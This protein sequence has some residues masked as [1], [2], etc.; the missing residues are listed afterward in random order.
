MSEIAK[1]SPII[2]A[3]GGHYRLVPSGKRPLNYDL[4]ASAKEEWT[5]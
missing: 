5:R 1:W 2:K 3:A 4:W